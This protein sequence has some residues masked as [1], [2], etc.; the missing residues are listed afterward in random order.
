MRVYSAEHLFRMRK[1]RICLQ[2]SSTHRLHVTFQYKL[3]FLDSILTARVVRPQSVSKKKTWSMRDKCKCHTCHL[4]L[5]LRGLWAGKSWNEQAET[6]FLLNIHLPREKHQCCPLVCN[7][8]SIPAII[9]P[10]SPTQLEQKQL[11]K[12]K[13][14][15][16]VLIVDGFGDGLW[17][18]SGMGRMG[19]VEEGDGTRINKGKQALPQNDGTMGVSSSSI[20]LTKA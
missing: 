5:A 3:L 18:A 6:T 14:R 19:G 10:K 4:R 16:K 12:K 20:A 2:F 17:L 15:L 13:R 11:W 9:L 8:L 1:L 7:F